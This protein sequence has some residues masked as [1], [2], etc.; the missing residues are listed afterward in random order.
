MHIGLTDDMASSKSE[1]DN[2]VEAVSRGFSF[3]WGK[4]ESKKLS[5]GHMMERL[6]M[7]VSE[8]E[9]ALERSVKLPITDVSLLQRRKMIKCAYVQAMELLDKHKQQAVFASQEQI[10]PGVKRKRWIFHAK[11]VPIAS[12]ASLNT[13]DVRRFEWYADCAGKFVRDVESGCSL[14]HNTFCN[15]IVSRR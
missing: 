7:A 2:G 10:S 8:L 9:L 12:F 14:R 13:D 4:C 5:Q 1:D 15:P 6:E 11:N 3:A